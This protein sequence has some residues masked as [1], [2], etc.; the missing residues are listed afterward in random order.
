[1]AG[2]TSHCFTKMSLHAGTQFAPRRFVV[3][4]FVSSLDPED[5]DLVAPAILRA[6]ATILDL[7]PIAYSIRIQT[8]QDRVYQFSRS[9]E[10]PPPESFGRSTNSDKPRH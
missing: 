8:S 4:T 3:I 10:Q 6:A 7:L 2:A 9:E 5:E 1:M